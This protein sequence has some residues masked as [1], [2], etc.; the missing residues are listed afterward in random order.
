MKTVDISVEF[1]WGS[2]FCYCHL[3]DD[4]VPDIGELDGEKN[5]VGEF[6]GEEREKAL[7]YLKNV[8]MH[9]CTELQ[10]DIDDLFR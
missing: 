7:L 6:E 9:H 2:K 1:N 8:W 4:H 5:L 10:D 3:S